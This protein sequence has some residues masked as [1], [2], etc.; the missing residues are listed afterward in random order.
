MCSVVP[1]FVPCYEP[2]WLGGAGI[3]RSL[4]THVSK[5]RS[6]GLD[7]LD[8]VSLSVLRDVGNAKSNGIWEHDLHVRWGHTVLDGMGWDGM[9]G[10]RMVEWRGWGTMMNILGQEERRLM[11]VG[12]GGNALDWRGEDHTC[13]TWYMR[14]QLV[15]LVA[16]SGIS[17]QVSVGWR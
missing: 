9:K 6:L 8:E 12:S 11:D 15:I 4:G 5:V 3:H 7:A 13:F 16:S 10:G 1:R 2:N 14:F 17:A